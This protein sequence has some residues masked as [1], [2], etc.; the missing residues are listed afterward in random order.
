MIA[1][2]PP[3][4]RQANVRLPATTDGLSRPNARVATQRRNRVL[5]PETQAQ[6]VLMKK[7][8]I[9][10]VANPPDAGALQDYNA[11]YR[12]PLGSTQHQTIH[13]LFTAKDLLPLVEPV[14][15]E[16]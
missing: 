3:I 13:A 9:T 14:D 11:I 5:N 8:Q 15:I 10:S 16:P 12:S 7:W 6:N 1:Q 2:R 4:H